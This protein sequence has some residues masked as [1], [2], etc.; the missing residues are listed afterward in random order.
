MFKEGLGGGSSSHPVGDVEVL[1]SIDGGVIEL[2]GAVR[3]RDWVGIR[4]SWTLVVT[5][6]HHLQLEDIENS[7]QFLRHRGSTAPD[8]TRKSSSRQQFTTSRATLFFAWSQRTQ[9]YPVIRL[10]LSLWLGGKDFSILKGL[11]PTLK[12]K[13]VFDFVI[14]IAA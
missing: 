9:R 6:L 2:D 14:Q 1:I 12:G 7:P 8:G 11:Y 5:A 10:A 3:L 13:V 4:P